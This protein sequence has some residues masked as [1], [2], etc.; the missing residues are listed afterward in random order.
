MSSR[1][2]RR[3][4]QIPEIVRLLL[5]ALFF[6]L[7]IVVV[8]AALALDLLQGLFL[9]L[10]VW[11]C[12][13]ARG[14]YVLL[15]YSHSPMWRDYVEDQ[16]LP[17]LGERAVVLNWSSRKRWRRTLPVLVFRYLPRIQSDGGRFSSRANG[18]KVSFLRAIPRVQA[19]QDRGDREHGARTVCFG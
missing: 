7:V 11:C 8:I 5:F 1:N 15:I 3:R 10:A 17:R 2:A 16:I 14:S 13:C 19:W 4:R 12:W 18:S 6:P 9:Y